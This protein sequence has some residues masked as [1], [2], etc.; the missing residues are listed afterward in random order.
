MVGNYRGIQYFENWLLSIFMKAL[1]ALLH[2]VGNRFPKV[3]HAKINKTG[4]TQL[5][6]CGGG[7]T[8]LGSRVN[9]TIF[10]KT[11]ILPSQTLGDGCLQAC[12][13]FP[14]IWTSLCYFAA[15]F[16]YTLAQ[17]T[18]YKIESWVNKNVR[19]YIYIYI[20]IYIYR[21]IYIYIYI[22]IY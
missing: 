16:A 8:K 19:N 6:L 20:Y 18:K 5:Y 10:T 12:P 9:E 11:R 22:C 2:S 13:R 21:H 4:L 7:G 14:S 15:G 1:Q 17:S 3:L